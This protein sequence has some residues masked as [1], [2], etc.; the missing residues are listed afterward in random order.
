MPVVIIGEAPLC[1]NKIQLLA[2]LGIGVAHSRVRVEG[3][4]FDDLIVAQIPHRRRSRNRYEG[5]ASRL[6]RHLYF[7]RRSLSAA[8]DYPST[9]IRCRFPVI[10][11]G[12]GRNVEIGKASFKTGNRYR[13]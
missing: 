10:T 13:P 8:V 7:K 9:G 1:V 2:L 12:D 3:C 5:G 4:L 6:I 11:M